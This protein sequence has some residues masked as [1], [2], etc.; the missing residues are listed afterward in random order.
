MKLSPQIKILLATLKTTTFLVAIN[1][2]VLLLS[3]ILTIFFFAG[4][5]IITYILLGG[6]VLPGT[7][8]PYAS[9][10]FQPWRFISN[11]FIHAGIFH[12]LLN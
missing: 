4:N 9:F 10:M 12:F 8:A 3:F 11:A 6:Q 1:A 5:E 7:S 2:A